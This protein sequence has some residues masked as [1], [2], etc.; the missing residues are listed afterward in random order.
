MGKKLSESIAE[1]DAKLHEMEKRQDAVLT[2]SREIIRDCAKAIRFIHTDDLKSCEKT[3]SEMEKKIIELKKVE[4][5]FEHISQQ[6]YQEI[7]EIKTLLALFKRKDIPSMEELKVDYQAYL[8]GLADCVG[9]L[10][11]A[12]QLSLRKGK[13]DDAEYYFEKMNEIYDNLM[14]LKYSSSLVGPLKRKQDVLRS[15][16][17]QARSEMLR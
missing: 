16:I 15:Q 12:L 4:K 7:V 10:R 9:E 1:I 17:E 3:V 14:I 8:S 2:A 13:K 5:D 11:R 6:S